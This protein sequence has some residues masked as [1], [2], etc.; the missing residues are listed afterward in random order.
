MSALFWTASP[1]THGPNPRD[2]SFS[3]LNEWAVCPR[4][5]WLRRSEYSNAPTPYPDRPSRA[6]LHGTI[7]HEVLRALSVHLAQAKAARLGYV[8]ARGS[9]RVRAVAK[10]AI[11]DAFKRLSQNPRADVERLRSA[12]RLDEV[13]N[14]VNRIAAD[15]YGTAWGVGHENDTRRE[16]RSQWLRSADP[17]IVGEVDWL[18]GSVIWEF[19]TGERAEHHVEQILFYAALYYLVFGSRPSGLRLATRSAPVEEVPVPSE[20]ELKERAMMIASRASEASAA[21]LTGQPPPAQVTV[22]AC[23]HCSVR[24]LCDPYWG[25]PM[26][27]SLRFDSTAEATGVD[28]IDLEVRVIG[29]TA[30][31]MDSPSQRVSMSP[32]SLRIRPAAA[33][34]ARLLGARVERSG[35]TTTISMGSGTEVFW[36]EGPRRS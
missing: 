22:E 17:P 24:Q 18:C 35:A 14:D 1:P 5:Y 10:Q 3:A 21:L 16:R 26:T 29:S 7:V 19:K 11:E 27:A 30:T 2:W 6:A 9:F 20:L 36:V 32:A 28:F 15:S 4:R 31:I 25:S 8:E 34:E 13:V 33:N 12:L 23:R